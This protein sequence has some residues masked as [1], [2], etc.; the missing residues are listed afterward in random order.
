MRQ[1]KEHA[2]NRNWMETIVRHIPGFKGYLEKEYRRESDELQRNWLAARLQQSKKGLNE[3]MQDLTAAGNLD[4]LPAVERVRLRL[5]KLQNR[6]ASAMQGYSGMFDLVRIDES[7]LDRVY[8]HDANL[9]D[10]V[11]T[12]A[13]TI[14]SLPTKSDPPATL[15]AAIIQQIDALEEAWDMREDILKGME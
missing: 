2:D 10:E 14:E 12:L 13:D 8:Q 1:A 3:Y 9:V 5:D 6:I 15:A 4:A 7:V 11:E